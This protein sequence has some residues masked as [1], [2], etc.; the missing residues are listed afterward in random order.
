MGIFDKF[1]KGLEK[2]RDTFFGSIKNLFAGRKLDDELL[3]ELEEILVMSDMGIET[4]QKIL[5]D[6]SQA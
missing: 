6:L 2:A 1:M 4:T 5:D 3:E